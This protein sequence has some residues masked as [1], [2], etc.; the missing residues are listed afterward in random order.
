MSLL[1]NATEAA[2]NLTVQ[3]ESGRPF[4]FFRHRLDNLEVTDNPEGITPLLSIPFNLLPDEFREHELPRL[5]AV[6][7]C[8]QNRYPQAQV[9]LI[10]GT[11]RDICRG[12]LDCS[13][14]QDRDLVIVGIT[15]QQFVLLWFDESGAVIENKFTQEFPVTVRHSRSSI[16]QQEDSLT[17]PGIYIQLHF[18][19]NHYIDLQIPHSLPDPTNATVGEALATLSNT[20]VA[21]AFENQALLALSRF[22]NALE[23]LDEGPLEPPL[24]IEGE[25]TITLAIR[26]SFRILEDWAQDPHRN[27]LTEQSIAYVRTLVYWLQSQLTIEEARNLSDTVSE[28]LWKCLDAAK[29][30]DKKTVLTLFYQMGL[31]STFYPITAAAVTGNFQMV[32]E[33]LE[34]SGYTPEVFQQALHSAVHDQVLHPP[35][36]EDTAEIGYHSYLEAICQIKGIDERW[37][38]SMEANFFILHGLLQ[39]Q[40]FCF[41]TPVC[42]SDMIRLQPDDSFIINLTPEKQTLLTAYSLYNTMLLPFLA[43]QILVDDQARRMSESLEITPRNVPFHIEE[44]VR[45]RILF[46]LITGTLEDYFKT[47]G[48]LEALVTKLLRNH[49]YPTEERGIRKSDLGIPLF[50][51]LDVPD[52]VAL[53]YRGTIYL[54]SLIASYKLPLI[55]TVPKGAEH[56]L[57]PTLHF[58]K[59]I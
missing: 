15:H 55:M 11:T 50:D 28:R 40:L 5:Q 52:S 51:L 31:F 59:E 16:D 2:S 21:L 35:G 43:S 1:V 10:G 54:Q 38:T 20:L 13:K 29:A 23:F 48:S 14:N 19:D 41:D 18:G 12:T 34:V 36:F 7:D 32:I 57:Q 6:V 33:K 17:K 26:D 58:L 49:R 22:I 42:F 53:Q 3:D 27:T 44:T 46:F 37:I 30:D 56:L 8:I 25:F 4:L 47:V 9:F 39:S 24:P 45:N